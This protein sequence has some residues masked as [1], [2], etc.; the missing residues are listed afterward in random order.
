MCAQVQSDSHIRLKYRLSLANG[1]LIEDESDGVDLMM[2]HGQWI[3]ELEQRLVGMKAGVNSVMLVSA[4]D[5][6]FGLH[7]DSL[8][9]RL[10]RK[11]FDEKTLATDQVLEFSLPNGDQVLGRVIKLEDDEVEVDLNHPLIG[12]DV[13]CELEIL[14]IIN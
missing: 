12:H 11:E 1:K 2:G 3:D 7:D 4:D 8:I 10:L 14:D 9:M 13:I 6:V 5:Q